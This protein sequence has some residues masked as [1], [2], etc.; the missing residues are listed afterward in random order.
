[1]AQFNKV[2]AGYYKTEIFD[3]RKVCITNPAIKMWD[4]CRLGNLPAGWTVYDER[5]YMDEDKR[6]RN[7]AGRTRLRDRP[8][9]YI[10]G[11]YS[12]LREAAKAARQWINDEEAKEIWSMFGG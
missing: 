11:T 4:G 9:K 12:S 3:G 10:I 1:M 7:W 2:V 6:V 5:A 8:G